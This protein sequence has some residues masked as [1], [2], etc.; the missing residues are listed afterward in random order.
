MSLE[1]NKAIIRKAIGEI[2]KRNL[3][4][5]DGFVAPDYVDY[6]N[7]LRGLEDVKQFYTKTLKDF[8][9]LHRTIEDIV[10]EEDKVWIRSKITATDSTSCSNSA[11][12]RRWRSPDSNKVQLCLRARSHTIEGAI[13]RDIATLRRVQT[14]SRHQTLFWKMLRR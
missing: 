4:V 10:A 13:S 6:T 3:A 8:P 2:N 14:G 7:P 11:L 12:S 5:L 1:E 9:D